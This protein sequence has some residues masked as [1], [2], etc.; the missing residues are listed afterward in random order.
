MKKREGRLNI[1]KGTK[2]LRTNQFIGELIHPKSFAIKKNTIVVI[3]NNHVIK[4]DLVTRKLDYR[5]KNNNKSTVV[6]LACREKRIMIYE[7]L[8]FANHKLVESRDF[9][10]DWNDL[11]CYHAIFKENKFNIREEMRN[12]NEI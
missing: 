12:L 10:Q 4:Y 8:L 9:I 5:I 11:D 6:K 2:K 3:D 7:L 1:K